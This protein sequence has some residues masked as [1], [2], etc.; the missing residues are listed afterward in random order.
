[1]MSLFQWLFSKPVPPRQSTALPSDYLSV[2]PP[3]ESPANTVPQAQ[4]LKIKRH[5]RLEQ[6]YKVVRDVMLRAEVLAAC[7]KFKVLSLDTHGRKFLI[8]MDVLVPEALSPDKF[9]DIENQIATAAAVRCD[10]RVNSIYWRVNTPAATVSTVPQPAPMPA[11]VLTPV[12]KPTA[13]VSKKHDAINEDEIQ[14][15]KKA[16][17]SKAPG[18]RVTPPRAPVVPV[19]SGFEDTQILEPDEDDYPVSPLSNTQY[20][21]L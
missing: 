9:M 7:Y 19:V 15:F 10:L 16:L 21:D 17:A 12:F 2:H 4:S 13:P 5:D 6:L 11:P 1:M 14:A 8:M 3:S 18:Q 20:G